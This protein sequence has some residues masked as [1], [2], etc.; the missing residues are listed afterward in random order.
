M[1]ATA[2]LTLAAVVRYLTEHPDAWMTSHLGY[3]VVHYRPPGVSAG[4]AIREARAA[5]QLRPVAGALAEWSQGKTA[6]V[7]VRDLRAVLEAGVPP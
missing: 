5:L 6:D 3:F 4:D 1:S 2:T 7:V